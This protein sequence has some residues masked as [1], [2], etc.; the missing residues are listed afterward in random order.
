M[1]QQSLQSRALGEEPYKSRNLRIT[2]QNTNQAIKS[3][4]DQVKLEDDGHRQKLQE[5]S[6]SFIKPK[7]SMG[8]RPSS[9]RKP[10]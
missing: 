3:N 2:R 8:R 6:K 7:S 1:Q 9:S 4:L 10:T 5:T